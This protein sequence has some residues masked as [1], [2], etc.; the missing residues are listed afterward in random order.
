MKTSKRQTVWLVA[1][2][3]LM[4]VLSAYYLFTDP[5]KNLQTAGDQD[6]DA[7]NTI[8]ISGDT[9]D[10]ATILDEIGVTGDDAKTDDEILDEFAASETMSQ[11]FF[12]VSIMQRMEAFNE[13]FDELYQIIS[14]PNSSDEAMK[15]AYE[16]LGKLEEQQNKLWDLEEQLMANNYQSVFVS[17]DDH[18]NYIVNV[19]AEKLERSEFVSI[20][21]VVTEELDV[22][23]SNVKVEVRS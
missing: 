18:G 21:D 20:M 2:L 5:V 13:Q 7:E 3:G 11:D 4:V 1:M 8:N 15:D 12:A 23:P 10:P 22:H 16:T 9:I 6:N 19:Q 14:D 17:S